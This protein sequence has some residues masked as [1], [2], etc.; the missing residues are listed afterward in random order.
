M[1]ANNINSFAHS[2]RKI[3][4]KKNFWFVVTA[5]Y[6]SQPVQSC[7]KHGVRSGS[8]NSH[9]PE[10]WHQI[11]SKQRTAQVGKRKRESRRARLLTHCMTL[12]RKFHIKEKK[13]CV[14]HSPL[15]QPLTKQNMELL[16]LHKNE[17]RKMY[18]ILHYFIYQHKKHLFKHKVWITL[19]IKT[20]FPSEDIS[21]L[22][23]LN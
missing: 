3:K 7:K 18:L 10:E 21:F 15:W 22:T 19:T 14:N 17:W 9:F 13:L 1:Q 4:E 8:I 16:A 6:V 11:L 5:A 12:Q 2:F 23:V 20:P